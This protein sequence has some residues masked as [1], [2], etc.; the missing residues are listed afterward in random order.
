MMKNKLAPII[1]FAAAA[2]MVGGSH[3]AAKEAY[4]PQIVRSP[5]PGE[6]NEY[7]T[8]ARIGD[9]ICVPGWAE[10]QRPDSKKTKK[11]KDEL[12]A[13]QIDQ[14]PTHYELDHV[15]SIQLGGAL[16]NPQNLWLEPYKEKG[17]GGARDK[18]VVETYLKGEVCA[19]RMLLAEAQKIVSS[20]RWYDLYKQIKKDEVLSEDIDN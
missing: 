19:G 4:Y 10:K 14:D 5:V 12:L 7:I 20:V 16:L 3:Q 18:D 1:F 8:Q 13:K 11:I 2:L 15:I 6:V 17:K 9:T